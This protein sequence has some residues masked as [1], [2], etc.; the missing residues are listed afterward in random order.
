[1]AANTDTTGAA[2]PP[3]HAAYPAPK[4]LAAAISREAVLGMLNGSKDTAGRDF[5][6][7]DLRRND[8]EGGTIRGSINLPA[9]SLWPTLSTFYELVKSA[10]LRKVIWYCGSS[11]GRGTRAA[12]WF[13]DYLAQKEDNSTESL[14]LVGGI[15]GWANAG[16]EYVQWM[17]EYDES[18]WRK[19]S[20]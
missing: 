7:V 12:G 5:V 15:K 6:L 2:P 17:D 13:A 14:V 9:Q 20:V 19:S 11:G 10:G 3:W 4:L 8:H 18:V 1:M 16:D